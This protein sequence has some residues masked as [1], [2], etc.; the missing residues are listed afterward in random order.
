MRLDYGGICSPKEHLH[1]IA[2]GRRSNGYGITGLKKLFF[3][4]YL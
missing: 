3:V 1:I 2:A 4:L